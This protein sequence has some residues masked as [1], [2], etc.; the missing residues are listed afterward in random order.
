LGVRIAV[1]V[2]INI[3]P[4]LSHLTE[5][6]DVIEVEG[7]TVGECLNQLAGLYP[8]VKDQLFAEDGKLN[9]VV[10]VYVNMES[11]YPEELAK[12]VKDGDELHPIIIVLGG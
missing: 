2:K 6:N 9:N 4:T 10:E 7:N 1:S 5:G 11:S 3:P 8:A 12:P